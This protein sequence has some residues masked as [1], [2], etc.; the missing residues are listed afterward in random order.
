MALTPIRR[1]VTGNDARGKSKVV[2]DGPSPGAHESTVPNKGHIDFWTWRETPLPLTGDDD[3]GKW[4]DEFPG[5]P[6]AGT[7]AS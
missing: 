6:A 3:P 1:V 2:W 7:C 5:R 4:D